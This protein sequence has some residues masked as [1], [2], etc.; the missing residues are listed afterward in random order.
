MKKHLVLSLSILLSI[1]L[2]AQKDLATFIFGHSLINHEWQLNPT[3]SQETSVPHW[4]HFLAQAAGHTYALDGQYGFLPQHANLPPIA[5]WG[6]DVASGAWDSDNEPF[7]A[8]DFNSILI[9]PGNFIQ[10]QGPSENYYNENFSPLDATQTIFQWCNQQEEGL[11]FYIYENWPDMGPYLNNGFPPTAAEWNSYVE[12]L[13]GDFH[14]WFLT[15]HD[16]L[17]AA[18]PTS[19]VSMIPVGPLIN[20]L[21]QQSPFDEIPITELYEDDAPH[22]RA[23]AYFLAALVTYM[24]MY[25]ERA[26]VD[27]L[28]DDIIHPIIRNNYAEAVSYLWNELLNFNYETGDS[29]TFCENPLT[30]TLEAKTEGQPPFRIYPNPTTSQLTI[31]TD[32]ESGIVQLYDCTGKVCFQEE[33]GNGNGFELDLSRLTIGTY[34]LLIRD[35]AFNIIQGE[36]VIKLP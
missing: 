12:Y 22:G 14:A 2:G 20:N 26:P 8:A 31:Q 27:F 32:I 3:P 24:A 4:F 29:R 10:W 6:F 30:T 5:Q 13:N 11:K 23:S 34:W 35:P 21:L 1:G 33:I 16:S 36:M 9:T 25:E 19:C 18:F 7:S 17:H 28:V 15:Y